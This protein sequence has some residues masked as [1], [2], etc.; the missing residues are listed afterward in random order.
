MKII[1][2]MDIIN[3]KCVRLSQGDYHSKKEYDKDP[4]DMALIF[5]DYGLKYLHLV[6]L[7]GA[8]NKRITHYKIL[9]KIASKTQLKIDYSG[10]IRSIEDI[11]IAIDHGATQ[12]AAGSIAAQE[13]QKFAEWIDEIK[14]EC[15]ILAADAKERKIVINGWQQSTDR[16]II[17]YIL[18]WQKKSV[19][20]VLCTDISKDGMLLGPAKDLYEEIIS[21]T[22]VNLIASGGIRDL[23]DLLE[24]K[25]I[26]CEGAIIGKAIYEGKMDM[27]KLS[28]I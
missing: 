22:N 8:R 21:K 17:E 16:D 15:I 12:V 4:I 11:N 13:P 10:G 3:G 6:D 5:E 14:P 20:F 2:A 9:E 27:K 7:D 26:G 24:L 23:E 18:E 1:P 25:N 28:E 19:Q